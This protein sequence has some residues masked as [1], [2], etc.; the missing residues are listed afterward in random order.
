[1]TSSPSRA[2]TSSSR[3]P[4]RGSTAASFALQD[5]ALP[6][7]EVAV[8]PAD[9][10]EYLHHLRAFD[11][12]AGLLE[13]TDPGAFHVL[14]AGVA[15]ETVATGLA[16]DH[17]GDCGIFNVSTLARCGAAGSAPHAPW[18]SCDPRPRPV[19]RVRAAGR[20]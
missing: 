19:P 15:G 2:G 5:A 16:F 17:G 1:M 18:A 4:S 10:A 11:M 14:A 9:W 13:S 6:L 12:T 8:E 3:F 20:S 7:P